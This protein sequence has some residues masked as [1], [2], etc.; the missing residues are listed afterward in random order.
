MSLNKDLLQLSVVNIDLT[1][2]L[3]QLNLVFTLIQLW[4]LWFAIA[5]VIN[6]F[7]HFFHGVHSVNSHLAHH[8]LKKARNLPCF[9]LFSCT[10]TSV[11]WGFFLNKIIHENNAVVLILCP[12]FLPLLPHLSI[13][14]KPVKG[15]HNDLAF[16]AY[17]PVFYMNSMA[18]QHL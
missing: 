17:C 8:M 15:T 1:Y 9:H 5:C 4:E 16:L 14:P 3:L 6:P 10:Y 2:F 18:Q 12:S 13:L 11:F 7:V